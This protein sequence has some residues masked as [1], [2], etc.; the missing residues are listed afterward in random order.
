MR[1][2]DVQDALT[3][4]AE[5]P[6]QG[7]ADRA[8]PEAPTATPP[9]YISALERMGPKF[10]RRIA[11]QPCH[12]W[13]VTI[14]GIANDMIFRSGREAERAARKLADRLARAGVPSEIE[15]RLRDGTLAAKFLSQATAQRGANDNVGAA[16]LAEAP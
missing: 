15:L 3:R 13:R 5:W 2:A 1:L 6:E 16:A 12:G 7:A 9:P 14:D 10:M 8:H 11:V 4:L